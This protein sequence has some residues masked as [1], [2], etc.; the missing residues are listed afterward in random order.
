[1]GRA[2]LIASLLF[3][4]PAFA[5]VG[6]VG[7]SR[8][9]GAGSTLGYNQTQ[10]T[11]GLSAGWYCKNS[12]LSATGQAVGYMILYDASGHPHAIPYC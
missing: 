1:M 4:A 2:I 11:S 5:Q 8:N 6:G 9:A 10:P 12:A 3:V 7:V